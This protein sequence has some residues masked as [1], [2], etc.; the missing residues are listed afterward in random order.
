MVKQILNIICKIIKFLWRILRHVILFPMY[1]SM[2][3]K[4]SGVTYQDW[5]NEYNKKND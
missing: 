5:L 1:C 2:P 3:D 4:Y